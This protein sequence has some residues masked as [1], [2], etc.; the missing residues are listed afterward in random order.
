[1]TIFRKPL[2]HMSKIRL[3]VLLAA[4][5]W[6]AVQAKSVDWVLMSRHGECVEM[7][8][9]LRHQFADL[10]LITNPDQFVAELRH[11]GLK[12]SVDRGLEQQG[13]MVLVTVPERELS[14]AFAHRARCA[15]V[16]SGPT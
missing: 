2:T 9:A 13:G 14:M 12:V 1:M 6:T 7:A 5:P 4:L 8:S 16:A 3:V 10:P 15:A 11:R